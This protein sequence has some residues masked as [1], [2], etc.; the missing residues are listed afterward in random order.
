MILII[1]VSCRTL[2]VKIKWKKKRKT[3][4]AVINQSKRYSMPTEHIKQLPPTRL[5]HASV[6]RS[7]D[8]IL[9]LCLW[10][11]K[12]MQQSQKKW[13]QRSQIP[14]WRKI[15]SSSRSSK[16]QM[17]N[18]RA[19]FCLNLYQDPTNSTAKVIFRITL[20]RWTDESHAG[21]IG[22]KCPEK[23]KERD[24]SPCSACQPSED[25]RSCCH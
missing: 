4:N 9:K 14:F 19:Y 16:T 23:K 22:P 1:V 21:V 5:P 17:W 13:N 15:S 6:G 24:S 3:W 10:S 8:F 2:V 11:I 18:V 7:D 20:H 25:I 12:K